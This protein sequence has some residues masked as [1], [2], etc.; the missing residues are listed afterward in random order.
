MVF[1]IDGADACAAYVRAHDRVAFMFEIDAAA[2]AHLGSRAAR[3]CVVS[4]R[5]TSAAAG[6]H[7]IDYPALVRWCAD[8][9]RVVS[10]R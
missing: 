8:A 3:I 6:D 2:Y 10:W 5:G 4:T 1:S 7:T 9:A